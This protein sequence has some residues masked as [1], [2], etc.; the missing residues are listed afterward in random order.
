MEETGPEGILGPLQVPRTFQRHTSHHCPCSSGLALGS[1]G[2]LAQLAHTQKRYVPR[3]K[4]RRTDGCQAKATLCPL[5]L[6]AR[7]TC[8]RHA[9]PGS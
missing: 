1:E 6:P 4:D 9:A 5:S 2:T 8:P 7:T 3:R